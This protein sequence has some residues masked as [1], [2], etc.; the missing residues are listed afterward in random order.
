MDQTRKHQ[1]SLRGASVKEITRDALLEKVS[2]ER[3][4]RNY[5]RRATAAALF[6]QRVWRRYKVTKAV[7]LQLQ[8]E[9]ESLLNRNAGVMTGTWIS[10]AVLRPFLFFTAC[11]SVQRQKIQVR[12]I[13]CMQKC[14]RILLESLNS[15]DIKENFC[16]LATSTLEERRVWAFQTRKLIS[17]CLFILSEFNK[18]HTGC[19]DIIVLTSLA[20]RL[21]VFLTDLKRWK[22]I[23]AD[24]RQDADIAVK[25]LIC[26]MGSS[27]SDTDGR[28]MLDV[29]NAAEQYCV[30]LVT[31]PWL[32]QRLPSVLVPALKHKSILSP[33]FQTILALA[34]LERENFN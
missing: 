9:W 12:D 22:S 31:I 34:D 18:S 11:L 13:N 6:I 15:T 10:N 25:D 24:N 30:F 27:K 8:E 14:F 28:V 21:V 4:L 33:C 17:L 7:A 29:H 5:A 2:Q 23:T 3:E 1:V 19:Q 16:S 32:V 20:M 26:F